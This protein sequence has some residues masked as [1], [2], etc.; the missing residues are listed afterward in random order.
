MTKQSILICLIIII[1]ISSRMPSL[2]NSRYI[3]VPGVS[4]HGQ[5]A[6]VAVWDLDKNGKPEMILMAYHYQKG[7]N[8]FRYTV[9]RDLAPTGEAVSW[10]GNYIEI[11]GVGEQAHGAG[12]AIG[13]INVNGK[14]DMIF[15]AYD[16]PKRQNRFRYKIGW[17]VDAAGIAS[18]WSMYVEVDGLG[19]IAEG[20]GVALADLDRNGR[21]ELLLMAYDSPPGAGSF[22][23]K[24]GWNLNSGAIAT[25]WTT[26]EVE[27]VG[28]EADGAG[29]GLADLDQNR[30]PELILLAYNKQKGENIFRYKIGW[31]LDKSLKVKNWTVVEAPGMGHTAQG[32]GLALWDMLRNGKPE[33]ILLAY[34]T[35]KEENTFRYRVAGVP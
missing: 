12:I 2:A 6:G 3:S 24:V 35:T 30:I 19:H 25:S 9:G 22:R 26:V 21:P 29:I 13:D 23:Y 34:D 5:G 33:L 32:A 16:A 27:G 7:V 14:P 8:S 20:A 11:E 31:N 1:L 10:T 28:H 17:D 4:T 18:R 15:M